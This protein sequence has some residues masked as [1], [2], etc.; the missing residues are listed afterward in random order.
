VELVGD[1]EENG[2]ALIKGLIPAEVARAFVARF[3]MA[4]GGGPI[5]LSRA[6]VYAPVLKRA[7]FDVSAQF[8]QPMEFFLWGL[9][10]TISQLLGRELL[11]TYNYFRIYRQG[12]VC[13]V[14]SDRP[15]S[16]H[17][18]SLTL[19]YSD[20][21]P[22]DLQVGKEKLDALYPLSEDFGEMPYSSV[23]ME[24]G[25][26][27]LYRG[28]ER[29]HGRMEPNPNAWSA[30]LFMFYVDRHGPFS[31]HAFDGVKFDRVDFAFT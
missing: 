14:H 21:T 27:V 5:P 26:A 15:S 9:T 24:V 20:D 28:S 18:I 3:K 6:G 11:P 10:P 30:H 4:T 25:D 23:R 1:Y 7:A 29:A 19:E 12:D 13:L 31:D 16:E 17:G 8:F 2:Y 22:W